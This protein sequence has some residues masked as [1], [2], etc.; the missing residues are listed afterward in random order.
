MEVY[1]VLKKGKI[2]LI[3]YIVCV[4]FNDTNQQNVVQIITVSHNLRQMS[5]LQTS[6]M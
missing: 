5:P 2:N 3:I 4:S 6:E 1:E